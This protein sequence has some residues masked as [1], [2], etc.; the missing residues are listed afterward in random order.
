MKTIDFDQPVRNLAHQNLEFVDQ[1][2]ELGFTKI[3]VPGMLDSV[4]RFVTLNKGCRI[5]GIPKDKVVAYFK[6][7]GYEV[8]NDDK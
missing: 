8:I 3:T 2:V 5:M 7:A 4:G 1:M 6:D